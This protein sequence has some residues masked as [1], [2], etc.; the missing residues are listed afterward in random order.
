MLHSYRF[1]Q[2]AMPVVGSLILCQ[3]SGCNNVIAHV[4]ICCVNAT[5]SWT[6]TTLVPDDAHATGDV[7]SVIAY[8]GYTI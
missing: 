2:R 6:Y 8:F 5:T 4:R 3:I 1:R 7:L